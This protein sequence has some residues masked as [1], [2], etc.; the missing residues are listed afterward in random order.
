[1]KTDELRLAIGP[2]DFAK[3]RQPGVLYVDKSGL[4]SKVLQDPAEAML[5][6][7]PRRFGKTTNLSMLRYFF[8]KSGSD[9]GPLFEDLAV[10]GDPEARKHF[11]RYPVIAMTFKDVKGRTW[12]STLAGLK[13]EIRRAYAAH[14]YLLEE[15]RLTSAKKERFEDIL[16]GRGDAM[17]YLEA[18]RELSETLRQYHQ[19]PV[20]LLL[21]EYDTPLHAAFSSGYY[22]EAV[23]FLRG[24]LSGALKDNAALFKAVLTGVLRVAKESIFSGLNNL[25]VYTLLH[26][27]FATDF[28]FTEQEVA[29]LLE[30]TRSAVAIEQ[31]RDWYNGYVFGGQ[32]VYNPWS[33]MWAVASGEVG[34]YWANSSSDDLIKELLLGF[35]SKLDDD[36]RRLLQGEGLRRPVLD[37]MVLGDIS[38]RPEGLWSFLL[39]AGYLKATD[40][41]LEA[42]DTRYMTLHIP[43]REVGGVFRG[44]FKDW[45]AS[46]LGGA[47]EVDALLRALLAGDGEGIEARL[48]RL[49]L[50]SASF[51][52]SADRSVAMK[53]EQVYHA[54]VLG[55]LVHLQ[56]LYLVRSNRESGHGRYDVMLEPREPGRPGVVLELKVK[57][58]RESMGRTTSRAIRQL[59]GKDYAAEL[60]ARGASPIHEIA[61]AF[62]GKRVRVELRNAAAPAPKGRGARVKRR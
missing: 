26:P 59:A 44:V 27:G 16:A 33:V 22:P 43:N 37:N 62:D 40:V 24:L 18:L 52:D 41:R 45:L 54:F 30:H 12:E 50:E 9:A 17:L 51:L 49:L 36:L 46:G 13:Q 61:I 8:E 58:G 4:I 6:T 5:L 31:L 1:M 21:D 32:I 7:R 3:L 35:G 42:D 57:K 29:Y 2:S 20:V 15:P 34:P 10:W 11:G 48:G 56:P 25:G 23:E 47:H 19:Q 53:P 38:R 55:L 14:L 39:F 60:R 28:G